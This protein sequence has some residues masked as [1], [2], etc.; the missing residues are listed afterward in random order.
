MSDHTNLF[1]TEDV[2]IPLI[3]KGFEKY[4]ETHPDLNH[5]IRSARQRFG[6]KA[7]GITGGAL[8]DFIFGYQPNDIDLCLHVESGYLDEFLDSWRKVKQNAFGGHKIALDGQAVDVW[9]FE[10]TWAI[11]EGY[12]D[13]DDLL[14]F[15][16]C[17]AFTTDAGIVRPFMLDGNVRM[18]LESLATRQID[19][20]FAINPLPI[21]TAQKLWRLV[22]RYGLEPT[23]ECLRFVNENIKAWQR[24]QAEG[25]K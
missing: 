6:S 9:A 24:A 7:V 8:R 21:G 14:M 25:S 18:M 22:H 13:F 11:R 17:C 5:F 3:I 10:N 20:I 2:A 16:E 1:F 4:L 15:P 12:K 23:E 19:T